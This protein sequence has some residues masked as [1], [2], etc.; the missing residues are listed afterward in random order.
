METF[1]RNGFLIL[2][3]QIDPETLEE[4]RSELAKSVVRGRAGI[5]DLLTRVPAVRELAQSRSV[6]NLVEAVLGASARV[7]RGVYFDKQ[8]DA[9]WKVAWHQDLTI[10]VKQRVEAEG[11]GPWSLK[12]EI[13]HV[14]PPA[15]LLEQMVAVR[16]HLDDADESNGC[17]RVI[18]GSHKLG[19]LQPDEIAQLRDCERIVSCEVN[20]GDVLLMRPL[21]LHA[22]SVALHPSHRRVIHLEY[23]AARLPNGLEWHEEVFED[24]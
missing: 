16:V 20:R 12:A 17:L 3:N 7:I 18:P 9:N 2:E 8:K 15:Q 22:S 21:L 10:A 24:Q 11:F 14:Q 6:R 4:L 19:R 5:R 1:E 23:C 13:Q